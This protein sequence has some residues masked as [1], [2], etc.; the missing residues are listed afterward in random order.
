MQLRSG[1]D[2]HDWFFLAMAHWQL[3]EKEKARQWFDRAVQWMNKNLPNGKE[4]G[5]VRAEA[6]ELLKIEAKKK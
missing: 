1:G 3:G 2:S 6:A 5:R 4:L